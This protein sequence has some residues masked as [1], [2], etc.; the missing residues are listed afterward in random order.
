MYENS[1][2]DFPNESSS[3]DRHVSQLA[4]VDPVTAEGSIESAR[5]GAGMH[6]RLGHRDRQGARDAR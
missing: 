2:A 3:R 6:S 5:A 1:Q 4:Q